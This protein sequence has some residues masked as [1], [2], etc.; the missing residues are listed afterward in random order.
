MELI[1][2]GF[3]NGEEGHRAFRA[4]MVVSESPIR[5]NEV[6]T[7]NA[8]TLSDDNGEHP[9][10]VEI[11]NISDDDAKLGG[12]VLSENPNK[13]MKWCFPDITLKAGEMRIVF[14]SGTDAPYIDQGPLY[15]GFKLSSNS[16]ILTLSDARE[17]TMDSVSIGRIPSD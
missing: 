10:W 15:A 9:D 11:I 5:I 4:S 6:M 7:S 14:C 8:M 2:P 12:Y 16:E 1:S 17:R 13:P 3:K